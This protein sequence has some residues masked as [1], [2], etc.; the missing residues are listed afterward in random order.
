[1]RQIDKGEILFNVPGIA[2]PVSLADTIKDTEELHQRSLVYKAEYLFY[3]DEKEKAKKGIDEI[4]KTLSSPFCIAYLK[5][6]K[7]KI[8]LSPLLNK[9]I[10][11]KDE[12]K[13]RE[14]LLYLSESESILNDFDKS[15]Y[16]YSI[17]QLKAKVYS[18]FDD[19]KNAYLYLNKIQEDI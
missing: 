4:E 15:V 5:H 10:E 19:Y 11:K 9:N 2:E 16:L 14:A 7:A 18:L 6:L 13:I 1:M 8:I 17:Y 3:I 12:E